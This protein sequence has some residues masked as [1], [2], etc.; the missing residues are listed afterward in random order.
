MPPYKY[1]LF[2]LGTLVSGL[3]FITVDPAWYPDTSGALGDGDTV[4]LL[5]ELNED[6]DEFFLPF[7]SSPNKLDAK[8]MLTQAN[9]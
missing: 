5:D 2:C 6:D 9:S 4:V 7:L 3:L 1:G 8:D